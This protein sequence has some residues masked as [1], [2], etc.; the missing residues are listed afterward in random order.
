[1]FATLNKVEQYIVTGERNK[2]RNRRETTENGFAKIYRLG[3]EVKEFDLNDYE[4]IGEAVD[5]INLDI[6]S[7][8]SV[9]VNGEV[10]EDWED[11]KINDGD[12]ITIVSDVKGGL[13]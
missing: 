3:G 7:N 11:E 12:V 1:M 10:I 5:G 13:I 6:D 9:R 2:M 8:E 4:T